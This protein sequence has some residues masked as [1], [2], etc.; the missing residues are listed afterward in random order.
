MSDAHGYLR[1]NGGG[2]APFGGGDVARVRSRS[3]L[4]SLGTIS[5]RAANAGAN[6]P[7]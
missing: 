4:T 6:T 2:V 5:A 1:R 7:K 3:A